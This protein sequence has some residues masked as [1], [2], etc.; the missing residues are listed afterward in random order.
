MNIN[1][2]ENLWEEDSKLDPDNLHLE[3]LKIPSLHSKYHKIYNNLILLKKMEDNKL[4]ELSKEK[5]L[6][7]S[8]KASVEVYKGNPF[9]HR[10]IKQDLDKYLSSDLDLLKLKTK[11]NYYNLMIE[12]LESIIKTIHN[13]TFVIKNAI[14][15]M[16]FTAGFD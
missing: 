2:I 11:I 13:R 3:S 6:Y 12:Y 4:S 9:D 14:D 16:K 1:E 7:Y 8:G 10:V 15:V 5:W